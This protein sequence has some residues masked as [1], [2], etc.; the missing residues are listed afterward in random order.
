[1]VDHR[2][3]QL[4]DADPY[5]DSL[6]SS[7]RAVSGVACLLLQAWVH[8][9]VKLL[10]VDYALWAVD[11]DLRDMVVVSSIREYWLTRVRASR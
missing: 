7:V 11:Y 2:Q 8:V 1:M 4:E 6:K 3:D 10:A 9:E 5:H